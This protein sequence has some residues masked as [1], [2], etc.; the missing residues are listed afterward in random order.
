MR[1]FA[2]LLA[3]VLIAVA[4]AAAVLVITYAVWGVGHVLNHAN[5]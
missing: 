4:I 1:W 5:G 3:E 2:Q